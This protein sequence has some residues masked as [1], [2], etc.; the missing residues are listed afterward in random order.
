MN[1]TN[2]AFNRIFIFI[3]GMVLLLLGAVTAALPLLPN[4]G[5]GWRNTAPVVHRA[6]TRWFTAAPLPGTANSW[7][8]IAVIALLTIVVAVLV[9]FIFRQGHG[10]TAHLI[11]DAPTEYGRTIIESAVAEDALTDAL[12]NR[13]EFISTRV[14]TFQ[15]KKTPVLNISI[16]ARRGVSPKDVTATVEEALAALDEILGETLPA[17]LHITGGFRAN[18]AKSTR[19]Q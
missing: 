13:P 9:V 7:W 18:V 15:V 10:R 4:I 11:N 14:T 19:L 5:D 17:C 2:R 1:N 8:V 6:V 12:A 3:I 16:T